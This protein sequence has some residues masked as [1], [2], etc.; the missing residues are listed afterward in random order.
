LKRDR[1]QDLWE[2]AEPRPQGKTPLER[3]QLV[4]P[5]RP[6]GTATLRRLQMRV[7]G[8]PIP[9]RYD[10]ETKSVIGEP[11]EELPVGPVKARCEVWLS[12]D[13]GVEMEWEFTRV[14]LPPPP[15]APS[16]AQQDT[17]V[18]LNRLRRAALLPDTKI[19]PTLCLA[20]TRHSRYLLVNR[21]DP[22]H[23]QT[24]GNPEFFGKDHT[25][26][27]EKAGYFG[28]SYEV[29]AH[30]QSGPDAVQRLMDAPY[31]RAAL[32]QPGAFEV[33]AGLAGNRV[34]LLCALSSDKEVTVYP[35]DGQA[36]VATLWEDTETPDPLRL[37][38]GAERVTGYPIT[39]HLFGEE[40]KLELIAASL[41]GPDGQ[42]VACH[43]NSSKNDDE[44][45]DMILLLPKKPLLA[46]STYRA[47]IIAKTAS[48]REITRTWQFTTRK[49][50]DSKP[51]PKTVKI[52]KKKK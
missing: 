2:G 39:L 23:E 9:T 15:P 50:P 45:E 29:V 12:S 3:P 27:S 16:L 49:A 18:F 36:D 17:I 42:P 8:K 51:L 40:E 31:H 14:P 34:T 43:T 30:G 47:R 28:P 11:Q 20:A 48:G 21:L 25:E 19:Q 44:A 35:S 5:M 13:K 24:P 41:T 1:H 22:V 4:W 46:L 6:K 52:I 7:N 38:P 32:L 37:H 33:G 26:R 10:N